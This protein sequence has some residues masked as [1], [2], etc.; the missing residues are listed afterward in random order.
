M[1]RRHP[2]PLN[3]FLPLWAKCVAFAA[4]LLTL[5]LGIGVAGYHWIA[6]FSWVDA[7]LN[8]CMILTGM[9]PVGTLPDDTSKLFASAYAVF[10]GVVFLS[11]AGV[12][13]APAIH[14]MLHCFH[15]DEDEKNH[16]PGTD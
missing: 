13:L 14:R 11:M 3:R 9:G 4:M 2:I 6:G 15:M 16:R 1:S 12:V 10:S 8:A 7:L 5:A